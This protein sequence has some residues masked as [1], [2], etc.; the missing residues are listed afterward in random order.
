M[1]DKKV[2][3]IPEAKVREWIAAF[4]ADP[5]LPTAFPVTLS[6][7]TQ[8]P[9]VHLVCSQCGNSISGDRVHGRTVQSLP[10]VLSV[11]ASGYCAECDR[12]T[13]IDCRFRARTRDTLVEWLGTNGYWQAKELR[14]PTLVE[15]IGRCLRRLTVG[16]APA[17]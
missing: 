16:S 3:P 1:T 11:S 5:P 10:H 14:Q 15:K 2:A 4:E 8:V 7:G 13:H 12:L 6:N 9:G 17:P